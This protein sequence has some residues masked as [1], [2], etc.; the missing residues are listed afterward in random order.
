MDPVFACG[1]PLAPDEGEARSWL[2]EE[3]SRGIYNTDASGITDV[4]RR[5]LTRLYEAIE[6]KGEGPFSFSV[7]VTLLAIIAIALVIIALILNPIRSSWRTSHSVFEEEASRE[8]VRRLFNEA[9]E[10]EDWNLASVW[11]YRLLVLGL[12]EC[13]VVTSSPG[14]TAREAAVAATRLVPEQGPTLAFHART[15]DRVRYGNA[16]VHRQD[17]DALSK[18]TPALLYA[19]LKSDDH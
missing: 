6:W 1:V 13:E 8:D 12:D 19:F 3:L 7:L 5:F 10:D 16:S 18:L 9:V 11:A 17:V 4:I 14:L 15:F 2:E